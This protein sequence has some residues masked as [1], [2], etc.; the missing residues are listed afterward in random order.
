MDED[1]SV[2]S[3][4]MSNMGE[5]CDLACRCIGYGTA[6][7][8]QHYEECVQFYIVGNILAWTDM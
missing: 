8:A 7:T 2:A 1:D 5:E 6:E 4:D 3:D